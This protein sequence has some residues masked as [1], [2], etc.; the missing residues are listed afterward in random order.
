MTTATEVERQEVEQKRQQQCEAEERQHA[1]RERTR[2]L[3]KWW[4]RVDRDNDLMSLVRQ[5]DLRAAGEYSRVESLVDWLESSPQFGELIATLN[6]RIQ[7]ISKD[8]D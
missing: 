6:D 2:T 4:R 5:F 1:V 3:M 7:D 8:E